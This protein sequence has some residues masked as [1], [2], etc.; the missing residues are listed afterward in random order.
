MS[1]DLNTSPSP[2]ADLD[3]RFTSYLSKRKAYL[4]KHMQGNGLPDYAYKMDY[5]Y[6]KM[7]DSI[8]G[9][10]D[11]AR[12]I[13]ATTV[14]KQLQ[15]SNFSDLAVG[16]NQF[17]E[18]YE[19]ACD[20]AKRLGIGIPNVYITSTHDASRGAV[21]VLNAWTYAYDDVEP[22]I[23][24]TEFAL[25]RLTM[26]E[27]KALIG[28]E[29][30]HIHNNHGIY[31]NLAV[32]LANIGLSN[33]GMIDQTLVK[34]LTAGVQMTLKMW[35]RAAEV[36]ADRAALICC[37]N[38]EDAFSLDKKML[39]GGV[40]IEDKIT[41]ELDIES[42]QKQLSVSYDSAVRYLEM[43]FSHPTTIKR[44]L[45]EMEFAECETFYSW[46]PDLK[47]AGRIVR[48]KEET[49]QR[50]KKFIDVTSKEAGTVVGKR[51]WKTDASSKA[52]G[53]TAS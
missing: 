46:R 23:V 6:R 43:N 20:C 32:L 45:A 13:C 36:S 51:R 44:I 26:G 35:S 18:V 48:T 37:D 27:L 10:Y 47:K 14:A 3:Y 17:P 24:I 29:C 30:G 5:E 22:F 52:K 9:L 11:T 16:P 38:L 12:K 4:S 50:C 25:E 33:L 40:K 19:I 21:S 2:L 15:I 49:D 8:P 42:L 1:Y 28:H 7:L 41:T 31:D 39:Y 53:G 34:L